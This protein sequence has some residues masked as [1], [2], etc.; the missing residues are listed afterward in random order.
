MRPLRR[1]SAFGLCVGSRD[2]L[3]RGSARR[4][5]RAAASLSDVSFSRPAF[6]MLARLTVAPTLFTT[7]G[8]FVAVALFV[9]LRAFLLVMSRARFFMIM[10]ARLI[11]ASFARLVRSVAGPPV[12]PARA[13]AALVKAACAVSSARLLTATQDFSAHPLCARLRRKRE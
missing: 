10:R 5:I 8:L 12:S 4:L 3:A 2:A 9:A 13:P 7:H 6:S 11:V 1:A